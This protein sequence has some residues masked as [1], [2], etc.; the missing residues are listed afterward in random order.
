MKEKDIKLFDK[1]IHEVKKVIGDIQEERKIYNKKAKKTRKTHDNKMQIMT[2]DLL[3]V[4]DDLN[5]L[6][7]DLMET[8]D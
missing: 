1:T 5:E 4:V 8:G 6:I 3:E 2:D 7:E